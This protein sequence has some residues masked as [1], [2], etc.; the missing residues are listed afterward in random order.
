[1]TLLNRKRNSRDQQSATAVAP[2]TTNGAT[3]GERKPD[4]QPP[5]KKDV[6]YLA[7]RNFAISL[8][9]LNIIGYTLLG[10]EQPPLWPILSILTAY[11]A[12]LVFEMITA[13]AREIT[14][15]FLGR[16]ARGVYEFL[17]PAHITAVAVNMLLYAN[18]QFWPVLFAIVAAI[19]SKHVLQAPFAGRMRHFMNPSNFGITM[20]LL[21]FSAWVSI[22]PPY[23][24]GE[25]INTM[26]RIAVPLVLL[27]AGSVINATLVG[28]V[29]LIVGWLGGFVIQAVVRHGLFD[30][31]LVAALG[32][33]TSTAFILF[34]NYM[35]TDPGTT[36]FPARVQF[37]FGAATATVYGLLMAVDVV[38]T[39]FF[40]LTIVCAIRGSYAW[41]AHWAKARQ[42]ATEPHGAE[43]VPVLS[44]SP[45]PQRA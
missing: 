12:D 21:C 11:V 2:P 15:R 26:F 28:R 4:P 10:F 16:G 37:M 9:V 24:F 33:M 20:A 22:A 18:N 38:Y 41:L 7:L 19:T 35:I 13:W 6:R 43:R 1:M 25:N 8:T 3:P 39:L 29:P 17:L 31:A 36:P 34:T 14:P 42:R 30:V 5:K 23:E 40:A 32:T 44:P 45:T 27:V